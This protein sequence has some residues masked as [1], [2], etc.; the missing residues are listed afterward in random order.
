M[1]DQRRRQQ[2]TRLMHAQV[3]ALRQGQRRHQFGTVRGFCQRIRGLCAGMRG[4]QLH[5]S[6]LTCCAQQFAH[7]GVRCAFECVWTP[8]IAVVSARD[9]RYDTIRYD[10]IRYNTLHRL[11]RIKYGNK[12]RWQLALVLLAAGA[13][14]AAATAA[15]CAS[16]ALTPFSWLLNLL[17]SVPEPLFLLSCLTLLV[18]C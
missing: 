7:H 9:V 13:A 4:W 16:Y 10:K 14:A 3:A 15:N 11:G 17:L 12:I 8:V 18:I 6:F 2:Q 5:T 1:D